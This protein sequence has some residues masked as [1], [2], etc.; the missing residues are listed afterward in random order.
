MGTAP[1]TTPFTRRAATGELADEL[2][3]ARRRLMIAGVLSLLGGVVAI[4]LPNIASVATAILI[5]WV[6]VF[7][8]PSRPL[9]RSA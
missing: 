5:G 7:A 4:V 1:S 9:G 2:R 8:G 3:H 6:L